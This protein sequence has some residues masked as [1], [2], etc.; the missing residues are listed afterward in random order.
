MSKSDPN[1]LF[2]GESMLDTD[3]ASKLLGE[4]NDRTSEIN[5]QIDA[6]IKADETG[7]KEAAGQQEIKEQDPVNKELKAASPTFAERFDKLQEESTARSRD[8]ADEMIR[9]STSIKDL[10]TLL[11]LKS[12]NLARILP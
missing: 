11:D 12:V 5:R 3:A 6:I 7:R 9:K 4:Y 10:K 2:G 8:D 1:D